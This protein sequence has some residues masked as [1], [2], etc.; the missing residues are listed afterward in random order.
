[1]PAPPRSPFGS[2]L[3]VTFINSL[4]TGVVTN[5]IFF[6]TDSPAYGFSRTRNFLLGVVL[7]L[8]YIAA[9]T[10]AGRVLKALRGRF[11]ALAGRRVLVLLMLGMAV[12]TTLPQAA[13]WLAGGDGR[14]A[15]WPIWV[16]VCLYS[17]LTGVLWPL[18][19]SY[20]S[21]GRS[22]A[23]L[24]SSIGVWNVVWSGAIVVT[25]WGMSPL[26]RSYATETILALGAFHLLA[27]PFIL[28]LTRDP[29]PHLA[30]HHEPHPPVYE[31]L[32][33]TFRLLLPMSYVV[34]SALGP[35]LP[36]A[37]A[38]MG[39]PPGW[40]AFLAT[41][42][43]LPRVMTFFVL[44]RWQGWHGRWSMAIVGGGLLLAGF[45]MAVLSPVMASGN[46]A[47]AVLLA[48]L[49]MFGTG[50]ATIYSAALY[51]AMEVGKADFE[52]GG[53]HE[54]LIGFGYTV[55]PAIGLAAS[56]ATE[57]GFLPGRAFEPVVLGT[58]AII[59]IGVAGMVVRAVHRHYRA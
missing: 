29:A 1:V 28:R 36:D 8:T 50:M 14:P 32:L 45:G 16:M 30:E 46:V 58:V 39:V 56:V 38:R 42:W 2:V 52:A 31:D 15:A 26:I 59:A 20:V 53:T 25:Y 3:A 34:S 49:F 37:M 43:L 27:I 13:V 22:G 23:R 51:Y 57:R 44:Q 4:G 41:A 48:G 47:V 12:L 24:R 10:G 40:R 33:V 21:G 19:E 11:P 35:Y 18:V 54:A 55:G 17:P 5:G 7:G 9:A 6:L